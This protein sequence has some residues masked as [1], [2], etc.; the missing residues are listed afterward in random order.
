MQE[1]EKVNLNKLN[2]NKNFIYQ[3]RQTAGRI[4]IS[5]FKYRKDLSMKM[6]Q[7]NLIKKLVTI[8]KKNIYGES[9]ILESLYKSA[10]NQK[11]PAGIIIEFKELR[12]R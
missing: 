5:D 11:I 9:I 7:L 10:S 4:C 2:V 8:K 12:F 3:I 6:R 1:L